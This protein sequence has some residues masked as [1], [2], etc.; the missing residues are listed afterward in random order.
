M[1]ASVFMNHRDLNLLV[2]RA[3]EVLKNLQACF[4][5]NRLTLNEDKTQH[6][7]IHRKQRGHPSSTREPVLGNKNVSRVTSVKFV[8]LI[9]LACIF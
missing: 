7:I 8:C 1:L 3:N 5:C 4:S 9:T 2:Y 6:V